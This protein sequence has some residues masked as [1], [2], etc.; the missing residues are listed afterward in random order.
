LLSLIRRSVRGIELP[1]QARTATSS[2]LRFLQ[3]Q[4]HGSSCAVATTD[5]FVMVESGEKTREPFQSFAR[6]TDRRRDRVE[7][8]QKLRSQI[9]MLC[10]SA[11][12]RMGMAM[13]PTMRARSHSHPFVPACSLGFD[14]EPERG[15]E[16]CW[17][18]RLSCPLRPAL[19]RQPDV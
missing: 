12:T 11:V 6:S 4:C 8:K 14:A 7:L 15:T 2:S 19:G 18:T 3:L 1:D 13:A 9:A 5:E 10:C 16:S 17:R